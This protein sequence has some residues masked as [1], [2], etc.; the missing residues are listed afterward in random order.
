MPQ[1]T[2]FVTVG[3]L[4]LASPPPE[5]LAVLPLNVQCLIVC[6]PAALYIAPPLPP[7]AAFPEKAQLVSARLLVLIVLY[8]A[9]PNEAEEFPINVQLV[10]PAMV[11][12][13]IAPPLPSDVFPTKVH[14]FSVG[15]P[16]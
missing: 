1:N 3:L 9:P 6:I 4:K 15:V 5:P 2:L 11:R 12:L 10:S 7:V 16:P 8:I 13:K 14:S